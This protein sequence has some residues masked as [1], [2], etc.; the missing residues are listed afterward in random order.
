MPSTTI[1]VHFSS[2]P[3]NQTAP[4]SFLPYFLPAELRVAVMASLMAV[5]SV[6][7]AS[8]GSACRWPSPSLDQA[9]SDQRPTRWYRYA[10]GVV[11][12]C[13]RSIALFP[14]L[15][16][17]RLSSREGGVEME[18]GKQSRNPVKSN[19]LHN[20]DISPKMIEYFPLFFW[21]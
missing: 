21:I 2:H 9:T 13:L 11:P 16:I 1:R 20:K 19:M 4:A 10:P 14:S 3:R 7:R 6:E 12:V 5:Y 17:C 15:S 8:T 18:A